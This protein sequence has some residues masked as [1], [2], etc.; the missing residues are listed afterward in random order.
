MNGDEGQGSLRAV[1]VAD[2][3]PYRHTLVVLT[4]AVMA[5]IGFSTIHALRL[6]SELVDNIALNNAELYSSALK[7]FRT[8]YTSEVVEP[9]R[10]SGLLITHDY[11]NLEGAIP[12]P[13][14]LSILLG[15]RIEAR[16]GTSVRLYSDFPF[17]WRAE[18]GGPKDEFERSALTALRKEPNIPVSVVVEQ[19]G[20]RVLRYATADLMRA[21]CVDCHNS[22]GDSPKTDWRVGD[23]RGVLEV[24]LP[25]EAEE[26]E[27]RATLR[28]FL[29]FVAGVA[30]CGLAV[31]ALFALG[32]RNKS[33]LAAALAAET[34]EV[35]V[36]L[37]HQIAE[38]ERAEAE[39][40]E[41]E[42]QM[43]HT[44]KLET[45]GLLA[46]G[47][48]HDFNNLLM[49]IRGNASLAKAGLP[50]D[51]ATQQSIEAIESAAQRA[52]DLT[53]QL[54]AYAGK[55]RVAK[56]PLDL[57]SLVREAQLLLAT[58]ITR[59]CELVYEL[60]DRLLPIEVE[61]TQ[62]HQVVLNLVTN[63]IESLG[64]GSGRVT[65]RTGRMTASRSF[66]Q[67]CLLG[68]DLAEGE[69][70]YLEVEDGGVGIDLSTLGKIFDPF[71][72]TKSEGRGLGLAALQ[73]IVR[74]HGGA[75]TVESTAGVG[76]RFRILFA[77]TDKKVVPA[78]RSL[79]TMEDATGPESLAAKL[80]RTVLLVDD[81]DDVRNITSA[82]LARGGF[83]VLPASSGEEGIELFLQRGEEV[84]LV[85]LDLRMPGIGGAETCRRLRD[86]DRKLPIV[87]VSGHGI[88]EE[89][90]ELTREP[91]TVF[92]QKPYGLT[93]LL[94]VL[95]SFPVDPT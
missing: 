68:V 15:N 54:L 70:I 57:S 9:A 14:T 58:G 34:A 44:Q 38:R 94:Q 87:L 7:E 85:L 60:D 12:L 67:G 37:A 56:L 62:I 47:I 25:V 81:A 8:L 27:A 86:L 72:T 63:A 50:P 51:S 49:G 74:G 3:L 79:P 33:L 95:D 80:G 36:T 32:L 82:L 5:A 75:L 24:I 30:F 26:T 2:P 77:P 22:H 1:T 61:P 66:L 71:Y 90:S 84:D 89:V 35:N 28:D 55:G 88:E 39:R 13:A 92:L 91:C 20:R 52:Q 78:A 40:G 42:E 73:G 17:P 53:G 19:Q 18:T 43:R 29:G 10:N 46:G 48:A 11:R 65:V 93:G 64:P 6:E 16:A 31:L 23:V 45:I 4:I 83:V 69:Y 76:T 41:F 59:G 21:S